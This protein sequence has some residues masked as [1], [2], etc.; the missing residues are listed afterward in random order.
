M[1]L[2]DEQLKALAEWLDANIEVCL[3]EA[4]IKIA[5]YQFLCPES[6]EE[7]LLSAEG[8]DAVMDACDEHGLSHRY[9]IADE[10]WKSCWGEEKKGEFIY[11]LSP[12]PDC[13]SLMV[14]NVAKRGMGK[15]RQE[16]LIAAVLKMLE[17]K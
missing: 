4:A 2:T 5:K 13:D 14:P 3:T 15:T 9:K 1:T 12:K 8:Q 16:A 7:W 17:A 10:D 11:Y 6:F